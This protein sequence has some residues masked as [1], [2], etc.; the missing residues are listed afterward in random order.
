MSDADKQVVNQDQ[1]KQKDNLISMIGRKRKAQTEP[2]TIT[3]SGGVC[4]VEWKPK[5]P[6]A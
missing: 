1:S 5:R 4:H 2:Q 6:A 3:C